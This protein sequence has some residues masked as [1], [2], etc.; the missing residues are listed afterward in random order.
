MGAAGAVEVLFRGR[1]ETERRQQVEE[2]EARF[3]TPLAAAKYGFIDDVILPR[4]TR[5]R[6]CAELALLRDKRVEAPKRKHGNPP[7]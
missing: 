7:L 6:L 3:N 4:H 2:Y 5:S 1:P